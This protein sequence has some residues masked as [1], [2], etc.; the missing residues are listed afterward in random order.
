MIKNFTRLA[1]AASTTAALAFLAPSQAHAASS[2]WGAISLGNND[3]NVA[4]AAGYSSWQAA[5]NAANSKCGYT[6]CGYVITWTSSQC[7][8]AAVDFNGHWGWAVEDTL[9]YAEHVAMGWAGPGSAVQVAG[10]ESILIS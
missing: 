3:R 1:I 6:D 2:T 4:I 5:A 10:C 7:G 8:A 9:S